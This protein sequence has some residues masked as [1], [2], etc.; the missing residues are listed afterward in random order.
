MDED[1]LEDDVLEA[2]SIAAMQHAHGYR[3]RASALSFY[4][5]PAGGGSGRISAADLNVLKEKFPQLC[6]FSTEFLQ[7]RTMDELL[8]IAST[9]LRIKDAERARETEDRLAANKSALNSK[10]FEVQAGATT[11]GAS[12]TQPDF[13]LELQ[14]PPRPSTSGPERFMA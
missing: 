9:S 12:S 3:P 4:P 10:F 11:D 14:P 2:N 5:D 6:D 1:D 7:S 8:R 13:C